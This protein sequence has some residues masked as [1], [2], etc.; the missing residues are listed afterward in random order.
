MRVVAI[1]S[2]DVMSIEEFL[3]WELEGGK[4]SYEANLPDGEPSWDE[5]SIE[6]KISLMAHSMEF[7]LLANEVE[8]RKEN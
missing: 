5:L 8:F 6:D 7:D 1:T 2:M 3:L 4:S